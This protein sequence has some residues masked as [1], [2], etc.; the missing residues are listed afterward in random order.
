MQS[1]AYAKQ[2]GLW[3]CSLPKN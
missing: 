1:R 3:G 2:E